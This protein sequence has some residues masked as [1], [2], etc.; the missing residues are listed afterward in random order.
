[1]CSGTVAGT[2]L[3]QLVYFPAVDKR[4]CDT[5]TALDKSKGVP[6][7]MACSGIRDISSNNLVPDCINDLVVC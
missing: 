3:L 1:M 7:Y 6:I 4:P 5:S 2:T